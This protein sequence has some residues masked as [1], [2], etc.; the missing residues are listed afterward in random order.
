MFEHTSRYYHLTDRVYETAGGR[1]IVYRTRRFV[2]KQ[3]AGP[4]IAEAMTVA[5]ERPDLLATR[6]IRQPELFWRLCDANQVMNP[7]ELASGE[8]RR[9]RVHLPMPGT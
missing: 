4:V 9:V 6:T 3:Q 8:R 7:F 5:G 1:Q 2:P